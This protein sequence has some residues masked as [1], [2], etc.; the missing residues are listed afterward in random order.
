M[1]APTAASTKRTCH[2]DKTDATGLLIAKIRSAIK[3]ALTNGGQRTDRLSFTL[4]PI[5]R[6]GIAIPG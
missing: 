5:R 2:A 4:R 6:S 3:D 1:L